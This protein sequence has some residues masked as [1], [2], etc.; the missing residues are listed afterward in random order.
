[1]LH[2]EVKK[3]L[4]FGCGDDSIVSVQMLEWPWKSFYLEPSDAEAFLLKTSQSQI[5]PVIFQQIDGQIIQTFNEISC[6]LGF[7]LR[8]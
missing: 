1:M 3:A 5:Q 6:G 7:D 2:G 4:K 8:C